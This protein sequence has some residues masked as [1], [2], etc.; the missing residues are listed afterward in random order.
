MKKTILERLQEESLQQPEKKITPNYPKT[1]ND[2]N[3]S[4]LVVTNPSILYEANNTWEIMCTIDE[5]VQKIEEV[6]P[7]S[8]EYEQIKEHYAQI[9][10]LQAIN[11]GFVMSTSTFRDEVRGGWLTPYDGMGYYLTFE[12]VENGVVSFDA[13]EIEAKMKQYPFVCWYNK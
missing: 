1:K 6:N 12:G 9:L 5:Y 3:F 8:L 4:T 7:Y 13:E 2:I 11:Y 10:R